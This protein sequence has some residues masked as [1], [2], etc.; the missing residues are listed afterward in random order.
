VDLLQ[1]IS[2][3]VNPASLFSR[4]PELKEI[5]LTDKNAETVLPYIDI[6]LEILENAISPYM[7]FIKDEKIEGKSLVANFLNINESKKNLN[8]TVPIPYE[9]KAAFIARAI[10]VPATSQVKECLTTSGNFYLSTGAWRILFSYKPNEQGYLVT[11]Y[12]QTSKSTEE[13]TIMPEH[14]NPLVFKALSNLYFPLQLPLSPGAD[15]VQETLR[16]LGTSKHDSI[17]ALRKDNR[18]SDITDTTDD[19]AAED[20]LI[21]ANLGISREIKNVLEWP[22]DQSAVLPAP[23]ELWGLQENGNY[24]PQADH[25]E[26]WVPVDDT[27]SWTSV[28]SFVPEFMRRTGLDVEGMMDLLALR[29]FSGLS[30]SGSIKGLQTSDP[31]EFE[32]LGLCN[33]DDR[34][35]LVN[36]YRIIR[37]R[38]ILQCSWKELDSFLISAHGGKLPEPNAGL[39]IIHVSKLFMER[40]SISLTDTGC[41]WGPVAAHVNERFGKSPFENRFISKRLDDG[42]TDVFKELVGKDNPCDLVEGIYIKQSTSSA[43]EAADTVRQ[44]LQQV[45]QL[46]ATDL[47]FIIARLLEEEKAVSLPDGMPLNLSNISRILRVVLLTRVLRIS[48][49]DFYA[50]RKLTGINPFDCE[51]PENLLYFDDEIRRLS[52]HGIKPKAVE[53]FVDGPLPPEQILLDEKNAQWVQKTFSSLRDIVAETEAFLSSGSVPDFSKLEINENEDETSSLDDWNTFKENYRKE[54]T[55]RRVMEFLTESFS[56]FTGGNSELANLLLGRKKPE[57]L[58]GDGPDMTWRYLAEAGWSLSLSSDEKCIADDFSLTKEFRKTDNAKAT[59]SAFFI[60]PRNGKISFRLESND[61][62]V[63]LKVEAA[64]GDDPNIGGK[65]KI[66]PNSKIKTK[67]LEISGLTASQVVKVTLAATNFITPQEDDEDGYFIDLRW[68]AAS[69]TGL[70]G[71]SRSSWDE[72]PL[73]ALIPA[74][75]WPGFKVL[76]ATLPAFQKMA[77]HLKL[78]GVAPGLLKSIIEKS[79][80]NQEKSDWEILLPEDLLEEAD[81]IAYED[82]WKKFTRLLDIK[83]LHANFPIDESQ[84]TSESEVDSFW[85]LIESLESDNDAENALK[86]LAEIQNQ[87]DCTRVIDTVNIA[88]K[89]LDFKIASPELLIFLLRNMPVIERIGVPVGILRK[90]QNPEPVYSPDV[91]T[92]RGALQQSLG[93]GSWNDMVTAMMNAMRIRRR[94]ALMTFLTYPG[95]HINVSQNFSENSS[96]VKYLVDVLKNA[97]VFVSSTTGLSNDIYNALKLYG[98][99]SGVSVVSNGPSDWKVEPE[100]WAVLDGRKNCL[101]SNDLYAQFLID[102]EMNTEMI[103]SRIVQG[104]AAVQLFMQRALL[105]L[106]PAARLSEQNIEQ[107]KWVKNYRVWEANRKVFLYP[108]NWIEPELRDDKSPFFKEL[109]AEFEDGEITS[110][111][112]KKA[113]GNF[114][115]KIRTVAGL[116]IVGVWRGPSEII[117]GLDTLHIFGKT[118]IMPH[119]YYYR[120]CHRKNNI[121]N[122]WTPWDY[123]DIDIEGNSVLPVM[124]NGHL[125]LFWAQFKPADDPGENQQTMTQQDMDNKKIELP[126]HQNST[127]VDLSLCWTTLIDGKWAE[128]KQTISFIDTKNPFYANQDLEADIADSYHFRVKMFSSEQVQIEVF[129]TYE[130]IIIEEVEE[131]IDN[132]EF[133]LPPQPIK[134]LFPIF[135]K[136]FKLAKIKGK[137]KSKMK[138][139]IAQYQAELQAYNEAKKKAAE[140]AAAEEAQEPKTR[141]KTET[142]IINGLRAAGIYTIWHDGKVRFEKS[143]I[144]YADPIVADPKETT[145]VDN[146]AASFKPMQSVERMDGTMLM[147]KTQ[148]NYKMI[149]ANSG[150][151]ERSSN[152]KSIADYLNEP[153]FLIEDSKT[154]FFQRSYANKYQM[155]VLSHPIVKEFQRRLDEGGLPYLMHR[156]TQ[157]LGMAK[158]QFYGYSSYGYRYNYYS[159]MMLGYYI[160]KDWQAWHAGQRAFELS[161]KPDYSVLPGPYPMDVVD[162][163]YGTPNGNYNW[164]LFFHAPFLIGKQLSANHRYDEALDWFHLIFDPRNKLTRYEQSRIWSFRLSAGAQFWN[165]LPFFANVDAVKTISELMDTHG[166]IGQMP[167]ARALNTLIDDWKN[168][169]FNPHLIARSRIVAYQKAVV[170]QYLDTLVAWADQKFRQDTLESV[171][172]AI[173]LYILAAEILGKRPQ[174]IPTTLETSPLS[175]TQMKQMNMNDFSNVAAKFENSIVKP[176]NGAKTVPQDAVANTTNQA[177]NI[178]PQMYYFTVPRNEKVMGYWDLLDDR[179]FKIRNGMNIEG[180]KRQLSLF[181]PPIDPAMLV[182]AAAAGIDIGAA[183][184]DMFAPVPKY[185]FTFMVQKAIDLC[186]TVQSMGGAVL[187]A[188]EKKDAEEIAKLRAEHETTLLRLSK[189][190]RRMQIEE[191]G[192]AIKGLEKT[193]ETTELRIQH[194]ESLVTEGISKLEQDQLDQMAAATEYSQKANKIRF[195]S[196]IVAAMP[197]ILAG[198]SGTGGSPHATKEVSPREKGLAIAG[199]AA[200]AYD[201]KAAGRQNS[202]SRAGINAGYERRMQDWELQKT[203]AEKE[204]EGIENQILGAQIRKLVAEKELGN[205][206]KQIAQ[207]EEAYQ[208][209]RTKYTNRELYQWMLSALSS[210]Y[211]KNYQLAYDIAKRAEKAYEFELGVTN[212]P[213]FIK[214]GHWD[215]LR[216]GL[217]AGER[218]MLDLR[219]MEISYVEKNNR[220]LEIT[221]PVSVLQIDPGA[222]FKLQETGYCDFYLPEALFDLDFPGHYFRRIRSVS[223][224]IP[225]V[226]GPYTSV[227]AKLT[228]LTNSMRR[229]SQANP[230]NGESYPRDADDARFIDQRIGIQGI[231]T[232]QPNSATGM[233]D[234]NFRDER[235]LPFEGAGVISKWSL[236]LPKELRQFDYRSIRD[237]VLNISYTAREDGGLRSAAEKWIKSCV[238]EEPGKL[239]KHGGPLNRMFSLKHEFPNAGKSLLSDGTTNFKV[240]PEHYPYFL[241]DKE[242]TV[243]NDNKIMVLAKNFAGLTGSNID[244][245]FNGKASS[246]DTNVSLTKIPKYPAPWAY[247]GSITE[248]GLLAFFDCTISVKNVNNSVVMSEVDDIL[249]DINYSISTN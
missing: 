18:Y 156:D 71:N 116:D 68:N 249:L 114:L 121:P 186:N 128:K 194:Y 99:L 100:H 179:L 7:F 214:D 28:M 189:E 45:L 104:S 36:I 149:V 11:A 168:N 247:S 151:L 49:E 162:F 172:E 202:A 131:P 210:L 12:P 223:L 188:L 38:S 4:R 191:A 108:E 206:E 115:D 144:S 238:D 219:R 148:N 123:I 146:Y 33:H 125:H 15:E 3:I 23:W 199:I 232:S 159:D 217:L 208:F 195:G 218:L 5:E 105:G 228:L 31:N 54:H 185:R 118:K 145:F 212:N 16:L 47:D 216:K 150:F 10:E 244:V 55:H 239:L 222:I 147:G 14:S 139:Q 233:F 84:L 107:W 73:S 180:V 76:E 141:I 171:N 117:G 166:V 111:I 87:W 34:N 213:P 81:S 95:P 127:V 110:D 32:I 24:I 85:K 204:L 96:Y 126:V 9:L 136:S 29:M 224:T 236:E 41:F 103:T 132:S 169:P 70:N 113:F 175:Y 225:C 97:G 42:A 197:N 106:E 248:Q 196:S 229:T 78:V 39:K 74:K 120:C 207:S 246:T 44:A 72:I 63:S 178:G 102:A 200:S 241:R 69:I 30:L 82:V 165:F 59:W 80:G 22:S 230:N 242:L 158:G 205:L 129:K 138:K 153:G 220:E 142:K 35:D 40:Y 227:S 51:H 174:S 56:E 13:L 211:S 93:I 25:P 201:I 198:I 66:N 170:M 215:G 124:L 164:E 154:Y 90:I 64:E 112:A 89:G 83:T 177:L 26:K 61:C 2:D 46:S 67:T 21:C 109:E 243:T 235:Y 137:L 6:V 98:S 17:V 182:R 193:R 240:T 187:S 92:F 221:K 77:E 8:A 152:S 101:N 50:L 20:W 119:K 37:L 130:E 167:D 190:I 52:E 75:L 88:F 48:I 163:N 157:A 184:S 161:Y 19:T 183:L 62:G 134:P 203:L 57:E 176:V 209:L 135:L 181:A 43:D 173:Q 231:A 58:K 1:F 237:I 86:Y 133:Q 60:A 94:D 226:A 192:I 160:A 79:R 143:D 234:F 245:V 122:V 91:M 53:K 140:E 65:L 155:E 27:H